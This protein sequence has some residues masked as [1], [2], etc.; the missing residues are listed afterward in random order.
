MGG[1]DLIKFPCGHLMHDRCLAKNIEIGKY[2]CPSD[3]SILF[4]GYLQLM[5]IK[6]Q[7]R[8][9]LKEVSENV[10]SSLKDRA[11]SKPMS[12]PHKPNTSAR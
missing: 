1:D 11:K 6:V 5:N 4:Q 8:S 2:E 7:D 9:S 10:D 3:Y 12:K